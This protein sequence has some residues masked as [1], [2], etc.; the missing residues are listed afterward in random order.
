M[1]AVR[2][3]VCSKGFHS[4]TAK[5]EGKNLADILAWGLPYGCQGKGRELT[6]ALRRSTSVMPP[7]SMMDSVKPWASLVWATGGDASLF[8]NCLFAASS[9]RREF[10]VKDFPTRYLPAEATICCKNPY[11]PSVPKHYPFSSQVHT[12]F[13]II[14]LEKSCLRRRCRLQ[15]T[16]A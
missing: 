11:K 6:A 5:V 13:C 8:M 7:V 4:L 10:V 2:K 14:M 12:D 1:Q 9:L 3:G 16:A 15:R